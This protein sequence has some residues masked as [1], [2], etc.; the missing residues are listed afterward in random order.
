MKKGQVISVMFPDG[1][2]DRIDRE[3][4]L[5]EYNGRSD[6]I[7]VAVRMHLKYLED[8]RVKDNSNLSSGEHPE[9]AF[10]KT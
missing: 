7:K 1:L 8:S 10:E 4:E 9:D 6:L 3:L 2:L 5:G